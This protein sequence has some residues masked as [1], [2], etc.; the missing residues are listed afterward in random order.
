MKIFSATLIGLVVG[1]L[2]AFAYLAL[3]GEAKDNLGGPVM[4]VTLVLAVL[5]AVGL[6]DWL[7][8]RRPARHQ[9]APPKRRF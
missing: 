9:D 7:L 2:M 3:T 8:W 4:G 5:L 1:L 6:T